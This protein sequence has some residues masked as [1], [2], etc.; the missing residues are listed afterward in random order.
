MWSYS[1]LRQHIRTNILILCGLWPRCLYHTTVTYN[2]PLTNKHT[3]K[4]SATWIYYRR[5]LCLSSFWKKNPDIC[6]GATGYISSKE[7]F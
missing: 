4:T 1:A 5:T 7:I 3:L 2:L 6:S